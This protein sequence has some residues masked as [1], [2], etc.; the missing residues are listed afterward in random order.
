MSQRNNAVVTIAL[1]VKDVGSTI[2]EAIS[3]VISQ[4]YPHKAMELIIVDGYSKDNTMQILEEALLAGD[5][6]SRVFHEAKGLGH[7]RELAV[8]NAD[9]SYI[10]WVDGDLVL[11]KNYVRKL[12]EF[13]DQNP[14]V[15]MTS[16]RFC[17]S[18][19]TGVVAALENIDWV[20][21]DYQKRNYSSQDPHRIC[22]A[23][24][25]CRVK[26]LRQAGGFDERIKGAGEDM[27]LGYRMEKHGWSLHYGIDAQLQH[28]SKDTWKSVW[29][30]NFWYGYGG[31]YVLHKHRADL[32]VASPIE[33]IR[34]F[35][36]AY[37]I[38][39]RKIVFLLPF[40]YLFGKT[41][42]FLGFIEAHF[43]GYAEE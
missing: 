29:D 31:H 17:L 41:A 27:D 26:A 32:P 34:R 33:A 10:V 15:G 3:S 14:K 40:S 24:S 21:G 18:H 8:K 28:K 1:C 12:V 11:S 38:T 20:V 2:K 16:G 25:I 4:D 6:A 37:R 23:G 5:L 30:E 9:G 22:C 42:W 43:Q 35:V 39:R 36:I 13:M 19:P 7:A